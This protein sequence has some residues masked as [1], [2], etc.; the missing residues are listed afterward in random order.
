MCVCSDRD[1]AGV[2]GPSFWWREDQNLS[3][4]PVTAVV[5]LHKD[6]STT[7]IILHLATLDAMWLILLT[8][9]LCFH[10]QTDLYSGALFVQ[11][12]LG[13]NLYLSTVLM[14]V[15]TALYTI[16]GTKTKTLYLTKNS[17]SGL[18]LCIC[19][20][21]LKTVLH[22]LPFRWT[23][24]CHLHGHSA[25]IHHDCRS[26]HPNNYWYVQFPLLTSKC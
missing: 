25:D 3:G 7:H 14:L 1:N 21:V 11:V 4:C 26:N 18:L 19:G 8:D 22:T 24:C 12:C 5:R 16:A 2:P 13:W 9:V 23:R 15:V 6:I 17:L 20:L 10:H